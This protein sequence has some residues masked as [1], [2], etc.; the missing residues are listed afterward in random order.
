MGPICVAGNA[1]N[2]GDVVGDAGDVAGDAGS[3]LNERP[4]VV[5][6]QAVSRVPFEG[7]GRRRRLPNPKTRASRPC[8]GYRLRG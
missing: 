6:L 8:P 5:G 2:A 7:L 4:V 3:A 1:G